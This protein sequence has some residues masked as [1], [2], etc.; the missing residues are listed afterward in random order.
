MN[1]MTET[2]EKNLASLTNRSQRKIHSIKTVDMVIFAMKNLTSL[3]VKK[4]REKNIIQR[5]G[6]KRNDETHKI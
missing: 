6:M 1:T 4:T 5:M 3:K 2:L